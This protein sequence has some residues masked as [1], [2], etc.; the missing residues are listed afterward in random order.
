MLDGSLTVSTK[1]ADYK[2][3]VQAVSLD[4]LIQ[5][6]FFV[7]L[8]LKN[9]HCLVNFDLAAKKSSSQVRD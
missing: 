4:L 5:E 9:S 1:I 8:C 7:K 6:D 2:S 3:E